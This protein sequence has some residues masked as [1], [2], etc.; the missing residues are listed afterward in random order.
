M[1]NMGDVAIK[2]DKF[3]YELIKEALDIAQPLMANTNE[4]ITGRFNK[5]RK[6]IDYALKN[7]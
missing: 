5:I 3:D 6:R 1:F 2:L 7:F 4:L